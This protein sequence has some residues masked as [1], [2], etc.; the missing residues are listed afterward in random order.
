MQERRPGDA[1]RQVCGRG[2]INQRI[3]PLQID[4]KVR[5]DQKGRPEPSHRQEQRSGKIIVRQRAPVGE[6]DAPRRPFGARQL[7]VEVGLIPRQARRHV[8]LGQ[9]RLAAFPAEPDQIIR[10]R[11]KNVGHVANEIA[12]AGSVVVDRV[13]V[14]LRRH[15]LRLAEFAGP[16]ADHLGGR[17]VAALDQAQRVEQLGAKSIGAPA[18]VGERG[19]RAERRIFAHIGAEIALQAPERDDDRRGHC[20]IA[21][22][23]A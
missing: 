4:L 14:I 3:V 12:L 23:C 8:H 20:R 18:I 6:R 15:H 16:R 1:G 2:G 7:D 5:V 19:D 13:F 10:G 22:R 17:Q 11:A 21:G 9:P